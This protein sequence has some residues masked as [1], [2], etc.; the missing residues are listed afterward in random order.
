MNAN[1]E[2]KPDAPLL[3]G[4][5]KWFSNEKGYGFITCNNDD[6]YFNVKAIRG[7]ELPPN[8]SAVSFTPTRNNAGK[9]RANNVS[10]L[11]VPKSP[12]ERNDDRV[13]CTGCGRKMVPRIVFR[14]SYLKYGNSQPHYSMCP[15]CGTRY[16]DL[17]KCFIATAVYGADADSTNT[18]RA[19]RD[20]YLQPNPAGDILVRVYY[21]VS[22]PIADYLRDHPAWARRIRKVLDALVSH[23]DKKINRDYR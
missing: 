23:C 15:F 17:S 8:G 3:K 7:A 11:S 6:Y 2:R 12:R 21:R 20:N 13:T 19:W 16:Q 22:P 10:I 14:R 9:L 1:T 5:V 4:K 18:L